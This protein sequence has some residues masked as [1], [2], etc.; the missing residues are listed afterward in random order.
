MITISPFDAPS[1]AS[2]IICRYDFRRFP[3]ARVTV[4]LRK[5]RLEHVSDFF[6]AAARHVAEDISHEVHHAPLIQTFREHFLN[7]FQ[8]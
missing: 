5:D 2:F 1:G 6:S 4:L 7:D 3:A 8:Y